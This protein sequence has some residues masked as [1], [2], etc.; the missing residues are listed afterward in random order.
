MSNLGSVMS[1]WD[2]GIGSMIV[3]ISSCDESTDV[4]VWASG[5]KP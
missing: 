5:D 3:D 1:V 4:A 2:D